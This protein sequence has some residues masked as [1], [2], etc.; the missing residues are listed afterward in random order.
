MIRGQL[1]VV[2]CQLAACVCTTADSG[3]TI[4]LRGR[5]MYEDTAG[6]RVYTQ[7]STMQRLKVHRKR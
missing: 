6:N 4:G 2:S 5:V 3:C 7:E 1:T